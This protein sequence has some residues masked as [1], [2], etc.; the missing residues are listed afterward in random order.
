VPSPRCQA[1]VAASAAVLAS[2]LLEAGR[3]AEALTCIEGV[4]PDHEQFV[5]AEQ[6]RAKERAVVSIPIL[7]QQLR[8]SRETGPILAPFGETTLPVFL[9]ARPLEPED[10]ELHRQR[11]MLL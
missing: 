2:L 6:S 4:L 10:L 7:L 3:A 11:A 1:E 9:S 8:A 5:R